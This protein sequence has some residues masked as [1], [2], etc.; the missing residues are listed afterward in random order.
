MKKRE[1]PALLRPQI[2]DLDYS[3][4]AEMI[5]QQGRGKDTI[6]AHIT[7]K[8]AEMLKRMGGRGTINPRTG[9]PEFQPETY[10]YGTPYSY[11]TPE[12]IASLYESSAQ[13]QPEYDTTPSY[14]DV[15][16]GTSGAA[17]GGGEGAGTGTGT[18]AGEGEGEGGTGEDTTRQMMDIILGRGQGYQLSGAG[19]A[20]EP[21]AESGAYLGR[22][23]TEGTT[24]EP[25]LGVK[26]T[27]KKQ[28]WNIESLRDALGV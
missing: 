22:G 1:I 23:I 27:R 15:V 24:G 17:V 7:P 18:G 8:E 5:R 21:S 16:A 20:A 28:V 4:L 6:L 26:G 19:A 12:E 2:M 10:D 11:E 13:F 3:V 25:I 14:G 9:I